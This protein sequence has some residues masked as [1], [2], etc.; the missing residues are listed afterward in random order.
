MSRTFSKSSRGRI[1]RY[2]S[3][4]LF[5]ALLACP[6]WAMATPAGSSEMSGSASGRPGSAA[7]E[8]PTADLPAAPI[9]ASAAA[10]SVTGPREISAADASTGIVLTAPISFQT[11]GSSVELTASKI[12]N[13]RTSG[14]SG[15]LRLELWA[16]ASRPVFGQ[17]VSPYTLAQ[18]NLG[19]LQAGFQFQ[20]VDT[21]LIGE[22]QPPAGCYY[23]TIAVTELTGGVY[24][25]VDFITFTGGGTPDGNGYSRFG[26]GGATC[27]AATSCVRDANTAC[28]QNGRFEVKVSWVTNNSSG[29]GQIMSFNSQRAENLE[30]AFY[31]FFDA[32]NFEM[33]VKVLNGC[34]LNNK[35]WVFISGLTDQ[36]W[37]L[38]VRDTQTGSQK[39]YSNVL[40][41]LTS[42]T[43]DT[44]ALSCP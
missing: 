29:V 7:A 15:N 18:Y 40:N 38:H 11:S 23:V 1:G 10:E 35:W 42:T 6:Q 24:Q 2:G 34:G 12:Q 9:E 21:G 3:A 44:S 30:S 14:T 5:A 27:T 43:A 33:G 26:F 25:Y 31:W 4:A 16:T 8:R 36:G 32:T 19:T 37:T 28:L 39:T 22:T 20:N 13:V 17:S 41:H